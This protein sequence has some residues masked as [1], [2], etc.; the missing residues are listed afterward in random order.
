MQFSRCN[1]GFI[2]FLTLIFK[3]MGVAYPWVHLMHVC[4]QQFRLC[5]G[6]DSCISRS[7][8]QAAAL[9]F[10]HDFG[11]K[12]IRSPISFL[13]SQKKLVVCSQ[14]WTIN[15]T[16][17]RVR[18]CC[19]NNKL[20]NFEN[21]FLKLLFNQFPYSLKVTTVIFIAKA[22]SWKKSNGIWTK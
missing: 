14:M 16:K 5:T 13:V 10:K 6:K 2:F 7:C 19:D 15:L 22:H 20:I 4:S 11:K 12:K 3:R 1:R 9:N 17:S 18:I 21:T 8:V